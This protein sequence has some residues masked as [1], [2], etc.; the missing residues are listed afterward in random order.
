M[1]GFEQANGYFLNLDEIVKKNS[2]PDGY[3]VEFLLISFVNTPK[4]GERVIFPNETRI[5]APKEILDKVK[6]KCSSLTKIGLIAQSHSFLASLGLKDVS[7]ELSLAYSKFEEGDCDGTVKH[8][9]NVVEGFR[10]YFSQKEDINGK[11]TYKH[12][13]DNSQDRTEKMIDLL[14]Q[15]YNVL[16]NFGEH[17]GTHATFDKEGIF[18]HRLVEDIT[19]Y[20]NKKLKN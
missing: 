11:V 7:N 10:N 13:I 16:S 3:T 2:I 6:E 17:I 1:K 19:E 9:R 18:A 20:L 15:S 12:I 8:Y 14:K 5:H 4:Y